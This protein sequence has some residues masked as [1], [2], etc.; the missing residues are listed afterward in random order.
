MTAYYYSNHW[1]KDKKTPYSID[2]WV[3]GAVNKARDSG[4]GGINEDKFDFWE[5]ENE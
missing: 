1:L 2:V 4:V 5:K 3:T